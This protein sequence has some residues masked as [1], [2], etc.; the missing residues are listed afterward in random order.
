MMAVATSATILAMR[1]RY[2]HKPKASF[3][4]RFDMLIIAPIRIQCEEQSDKQQNTHLTDHHAIGNE[5]E[6]A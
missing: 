3:T 2:Q 1:D 4:V 6:H 5:Q